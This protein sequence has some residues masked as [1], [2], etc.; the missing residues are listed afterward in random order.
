MRIAVFGKTDVGRNREHNEDSFLV[1]DLSTQKASLR[2]E[3]REH[4]VGPKGTL[5]VVADGMGGAA[6]GEVA[7]EMATDVVYK[8]LVD[9]W[10]PDP[11]NTAQQ[12][13]YR[14]RESVEKANEKIHAYS[15]E[16]P[17]VRGM[18]T[19]MTA[20]GA[21]EDHLYL[22]QVGDSRAYLVRKG[23]AIQLTKDQSLMQR[24]VDAGEL[25]EEEAEHSERKN[26]ILQALGPEARVRVDLTYQSIRNGDAILI[27]SDGLSGLVTKDE[28]AEKVRPDK[29]LLTISSELIDL[30]NERGG[31]DNITVIVARF[32]GDTLGD[33]GDDEKVG[34]EIYPL[35][36]TESTTEPV[37][38]Y[39]GSEPPTPKGSSM[40]AAAAAA[41]AIVAIS[42]ILTVFTF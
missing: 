19:T 23:A 1:A 4:E 5:L 42:L 29:D 41:A 9:A 36:D 27:C 25:T 38:V 26:I 35:L 10:I 15:Q 7:S 11:E 6:A 18:G 33:P 30:A 34:H 24:L 20:V 28:I 32:S 3:V 13:A 37:P 16:H 8:H 22:S 14:L 39:T 31:P 21:F 40:I 12:F 2:P 17:E